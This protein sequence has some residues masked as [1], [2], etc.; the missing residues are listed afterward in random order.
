M[1]IYA[2]QESS[3]YDMYSTART[4]AYFT[5][6]VEA[7]EAA[8]M[9]GELASVLPVETETLSEWVARTFIT[10]TRRR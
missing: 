2:L 1:I 3:G 4:V 6:A 9:L 7:E 5:S 10:E 8:K